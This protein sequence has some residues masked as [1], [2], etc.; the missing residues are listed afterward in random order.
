MREVSFTSGDLS[1]IE[2]KGN[3]TGGLSVSGLGLPRVAR[4]RL[5]YFDVRKLSILEC[6]THET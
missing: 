2:L 1:A 3:T 6:C 4:Y 5:L